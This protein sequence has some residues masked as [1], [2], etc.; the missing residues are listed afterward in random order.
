[1]WFSGLIPCL[2]LSLAFALSAAADTLHLANGDRIQGRIVAE[3]AET[4]TVETAYAGVITIQRA[5]V[6]VVV[7]DADAG[8][9]GDTGTAPPEAGAEGGD[10]AGAARPRERDL[11]SGSLEAG[12]TLRTGNTDS[13]D[14]LGAAQFTRDAAWNKLTLKL[15]VQYGEVEREINARGYRGDAKWQVYPRERLFVYF[16]GSGERDDARK[17][18]HRFTAGAGLGYDAVKRERA[19][20]SIEG[21]AEY[22]WERWNPFTPAGRDRE[23][24]ARHAAAR[25]ELAAWALGG[26]DRGGLGRA[27]TL[28]ATLRDPLGG[29]RPRDENYTSLRIGLRYEQR[30][31]KESTLSNELTLLPNLEDLSEFRATNELA[32]ETP[33]SPRLALRV[34][35]GSAYDSLAET[36]G[37]DPWD[38]RLATGIRVKF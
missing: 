26:L 17:L 3:D 31:W 8:A 22:A 14:V 34:T 11:W 37:A 35:L 36:T 29:A 21:G 28:L 27:N 1:M 7:P 9:D 15:G 13:L 25:D 12:L 23:R 18:D 30:L 20:L 5:A 4:L 10:D 38:N 32:F 6:A 2:A 33:L 19:K 16:R 24:A